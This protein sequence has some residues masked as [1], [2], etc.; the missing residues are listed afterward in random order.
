MHD[1]DEIKARRTQ[2][3]GVTPVTRSARASREGPTNAVAEYLEAIAEA[4]KA[5]LALLDSIGDNTDPIVIARRIRTRN[6]WLRELSRFKAPTPADEQAAAGNARLTVENAA[7]R[8]QQHLTSDV[9]VADTP[10][11]TAQ[12]EA[13]Q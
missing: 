12:P 9:T 8:L 4:Q 13:P 5:D 1:S 3:Q 6:S 10:T 11:Q 2:L 7:R